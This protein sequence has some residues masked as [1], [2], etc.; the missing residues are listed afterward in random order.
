MAL[1]NVKKKVEKAADKLGLRS[2]EVVVAG[3]TTNPKGTIKHMIGREV[4]GVVGAAIAGRSSSP[5][6]APT[7]G[8]LGSRFPSGQRFLV[9]TDQRVFTCTLSAMTGSPKAID[10]EWQRTE[11]VSVTMEKGRMASPLTIVFAD[12]SAVEVE[13][14][15]G[16]DPA[17]LADAF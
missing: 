10:A 11:I 14:A 6:A 1:V 12:G 16:S 17:S 7:E 9:L 5:T 3:C 13:G 8:T 4:G 15:M 2:G